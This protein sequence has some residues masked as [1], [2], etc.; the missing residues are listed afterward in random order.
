MED[1]PALSVAMWDHLERS[2]I[3][4]VV[5][6]WGHANALFVV[7]ALKQRYSGHAQQALMAAAGLRGS[8]S[9]NTYYVAV[10]DD[11]DPA[12]LRAVIWA[13]ST[14]VNP[15]TALNV[16]QGAWTSDLDPR[17]TPEQKSSGDYTMGRLLINACKPYSWKDSFPKTNIFSAAERHGVRE[18]WADVLQEIEQMARKASRPV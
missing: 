18:K 4:D 13:M 14:R 3:T 9:M 1:V 17:L 10:D 5:G 15:A 2:G 16:V 7:V 6:V 12:D 11:I 8:A